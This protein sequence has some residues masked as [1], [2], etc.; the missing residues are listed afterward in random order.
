MS[1]TLL[2]AL[3]LSA[4][5]ASATDLSGW[6]IPGDASA[7]TLAM[8][9]FKAQPPPPHNRFS[10]SAQRSSLY[11]TLT[12]TEQAFVQWNA[13]RLGIDVASSASRYNASAQ[14]FGVRGFNS[15][16]YRT[17]CVTGH[18]A[19]SVLAADSP[20]EMF[21]AYRLFA[22]FHTLRLVSYMNP[23]GTALHVEMARHLISSFPDATPLE[24]IDYGCGMAQ[25]S[26]C[27]AEMLRVQGR[28]VKLH[29]FDIPTPRKS[30][31]A[32]TCQK[33]DG[34]ACEMHDVTQ[35]TGL[36]VAA[37]AVI[38]TEVLEHMQPAQTSHFRTQLL[39]ALVPHGLFRAN[40]GEHAKEF[41]HVD[42]KISQHWPSWLRQH[43]FSTVR[44][45]ILYSRS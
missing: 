32:F 19:F 7:L 27:L 29:L 11:P 13:L 37:H 20:D 1:N 28:Q 34:F 5:T 41:M 45:M 31:L 23:C 16:A 35:K 14:T 25:E 38:A 17:F 36:P 44:N 8:Q 21:D 30:L 15:A 10:A 43:G 26:R 39:G 33:F 18:S 9:E 42:A 12:R 2:L 22:P 4:M 3:L 40:I 6:F 24:M